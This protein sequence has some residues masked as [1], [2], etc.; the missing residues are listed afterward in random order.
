M[1]GESQTVSAHTVGS[2]PPWGDGRLRRPVVAAS[3]RGR[4]LVLLNQTRYDDEEANRPSGFSKSEGGP[5]PFV[6]LLGVHHLFEVS[7]WLQTYIVV[8]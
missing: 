3:A 7:S 1:G 5:T 4:L 6:L 2:M 8:Q